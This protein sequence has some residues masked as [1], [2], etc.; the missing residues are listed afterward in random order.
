MK[1]LPLKGPFHFVGIGGSGMSPLAEILRAQ[2]HEVS[3]S[4]LK[5]SDATARLSAMGVRIHRGHDARNI[6]SARCL[7]LSSAITESNPELSAGRARGLRLVHRGE[8]LDVVMAPF[9]HRIAISGSHGKTTTTAM[10]TGILEA[11]GFDPTALVGGKL[12]G[13]QSGARIGNGDAFVAEADESDRSF[14]K[15]HPTLSLVTNVDREHLDAYRDMAEVSRAFSSFALSVPAH[16]TAVLCADDS[17]AAE[18]AKGGGHRAVTYGLAETA[19]VRGRVVV[20]E[21]GFPQVTGRGPS[22]AF[23]FTLGVSG[24][25]NALNALGAMAAAVSLGIAPALASRSLAS[26]RGVARRLE[27]KGR[28]E[29]V[30]VWDDYGHHPTEIS[31]TLKALRT[32]TAGRRLVT[33]FQPHRVTRTRSLW[34]EFTRAFSLTDELWLA[35][36]YAAGEAPEEGITSERLVDAI[37]AAGQ[38][39]HYAGSLEEARANILPRLGGND[40]LLTLGAGDVVEFGES[41]LSQGRPTA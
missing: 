1:I 12:K 36:I 18:I 6:E 40:V 16:G 7:V 9:P 15:L 32:R 41:F 24:E 25:M 13:T 23:E 11:A 38:A 30:D 33:L 2:G 3:G 8:L 14:L 17:I 5:P 27:W 4:D 21:G 10:V 20:P 31:A 34:S 37:V 35:S 39:A 19:D 29:G 22:G 28:R 26:F